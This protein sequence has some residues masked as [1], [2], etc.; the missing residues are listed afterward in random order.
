[1]IETL[2]SN[3]SYN[4]YRYQG[5]SN[6]VNPG[7]QENPTQHHINDNTTRVSARPV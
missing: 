7:I 3:K 1:M 5:K 2:I 6:T 4:Q